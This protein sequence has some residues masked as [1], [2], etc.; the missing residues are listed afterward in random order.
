MHFDHGHPLLG[1]AIAPWDFFVCVCVGGG[2]CKLTHHKQLSSFIKYFGVCL[3]FGLLRV[4]WKRCLKELFSHFAE[5]KKGGD[6]LIKWRDEQNSLTSWE[7]HMKVTPSWDLS[8][9]IS[10]LCGLKWLLLLAEIMWVKL[11]CQL[12]TQAISHKGVP[13]TQKIRPP[14]KCIQNYQW[15]VW[16]LLR[17]PC[18]V[19]TT[20]KSE[21]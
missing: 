11:S 9:L 3:F 18:A 7:R 15:N 8:F 17:W 21:H 4:I 2:W 12:N 20:L 5:F 19:D 14:V 13:Q 1:Q 6:H 10:S 16:F